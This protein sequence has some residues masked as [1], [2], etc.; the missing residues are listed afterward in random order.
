MFPLS[1]RIAASGLFAQQ[2]HIETI[3]KN[4]ANKD[5]E[6]YK[7]LNPDFS[8]VRYN[9][10]VSFTSSTGSY[11]WVDRN[12]AMKSADLARTTAAN[13]GL[14]AVDNLISNIN[15]E[16]AYN[17]FLTATKNLQTSPQS[18]I[19]LQELNSAGK[20]LGESISQAKAGLA[21]LQRNIKNKTDL[22]R[23]QLDGYNNQLEKMLSA[24][25]DETNANDVQ[26][27]RQKIT[28]LNGELAGYKEF[29]TN[30][31]PAL[32]SKFSTITTALQTNINTSGKVQAFVDDQWGDQTSIDAFA[33]NNN[34][35]I[36]NFK[37]DIGALKTQIGALTEQSNLDVA[38]ETNQFAQATKE[39]DNVYG[40]NLEQETLNM[41]NAQ[42]MFEANLKVIQTSD[43]MIGSLLDAIG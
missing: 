37:E 28:T 34:D 15:V 16:E 10:G 11:P 6:G 18:A 20:S 5:V 33:I 13:D 23:V 8:T 21:N 19:H 4:I 9:G 2:S 7:R 35:A 29:T 38:Y 3:S 1:T 24:G 39:Y 12:F 32:A 14:K 43:R 42:K 25:V 36:T 17:D 41:L 26:L 27:L 40:V 22:S 31:L 30:T